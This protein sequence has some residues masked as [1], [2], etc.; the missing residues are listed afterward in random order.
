MSPTSRLGKEV[1]SAFFFVY[2]QE[3]MSPFHRARELEL[4]FNKAFLRSKLPGPAVTSGRG[5]MDPT[6]L[7]STKEITPFC[8]CFYH[9]EQAVSLLVNGVSYVNQFLNLYKLTWFSYGSL[10]RNCQSLAQQI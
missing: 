3:A 1:D 8:R 7:D 4:N 2:F 9:H 10:V 5:Y 6:Q